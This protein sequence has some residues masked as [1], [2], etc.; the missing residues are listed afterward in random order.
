M[1]DDSLYRLGG[2]ATIVG[3]VFWGLGV[4]LHAP[5]PMT[6][7]AFSALP[8]GSWMASHWLLAIAAILMA[9]GLTAFARH[10]SH[11]SGEGWA[12]LGVATSIATAALFVAVVAPEIVAFDALR[13]TSSDPGAQSA[14]VAINLNLMSLVHVGSPLYWL[15]IG[16]FALAMLGDKAWPRWLGM[17]GVAVAVINIAAN[18]MVQSFTISKALFMLGVVWLVIA[19]VLFSRFAGRGVEQSGVAAPAGA[20]KAGQGVP[21]R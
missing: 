4:I 18:W 3:A 15:G 19:G 2:G 16:F 7:A 14:Y 6:L 12:V 21:A 17:A 5:Q 1:R 11:T 10:L 20:Y 9:A 13:T 8:M